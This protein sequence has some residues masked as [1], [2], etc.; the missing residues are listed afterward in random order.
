MPQR[1]RRAQRDLTCE[2][3]GKI[4]GGHVY[5]TP[6]RCAVVRNRKA[7]CRRCAEA[8]TAGCIAVEAGRLAVDPSRCVGC[9]TC[10][11][12]CPTGA[13]E[14]RLPNDAELLRQARAALDGG[15]TA[16]A[17]S[18]AK[19][20]DG[21]TRVVCLGRIDESLLASL[22]A[23]GARRVDLVCGNCAACQL[24][25][26]RA[27]VETVC[28]QTER[29]L[30][31][32]GC[33]LNVRIVEAPEEKVCASDVAEDAPSAHA[34]ASDATTSFDPPRQGMRTT[35][36]GTLPHFVPE[37]RERLLN[38]L[39]RLGDAPATGTVAGRFWGRVAI[40]TTACSSCR[41]CTVFCPTGALRRAEGPDG[42]PEI[43]LRP[44]DCV[45]CRSCADACPTGALH[46]ENEVPAATLLHAGVE[47]VALCPPNEP[48][49]GPARLVRTMRR[50]L[51]CG[52][53]YEK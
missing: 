43:E 14:A 50:V 49:Q 40:D 6:G 17:C 36:D 52:E 34:D 24:A 41:A 11:T 48:A 37:R 22:A 39:A 38:A 20:A 32:W 27:T 10:A 9:G 23:S 18:R 51:G 47:T 31:L 1:T 35:A 25:P 7:T 13:L 28:A 44:A 29:L 15:A 2:E 42:V 26:G 45:R 16:L 21:A 8:C 3:L 12:A 19:A 30:A 46:I 5:V 33:S 4:G 53:V